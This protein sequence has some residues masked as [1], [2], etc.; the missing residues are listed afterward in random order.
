VIFGHSHKPE[1]ETTGEIQLLNPGSHADPR[2]YRPAHAELEPVAD[3]D[4][5]TLRG[6]LVAPSGEVYERFRF[7]RRR[8]TE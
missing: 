1:V 8:V 3:A 4:G 7:S 2:R 6:R 5:P